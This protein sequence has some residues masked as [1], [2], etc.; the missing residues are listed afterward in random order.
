VQAY[1]ATFPGR[2]VA[3]GM[4][5]QDAELKRMFAAGTFERLSRK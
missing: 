1:A 4:R 2:G 3:A 5:E